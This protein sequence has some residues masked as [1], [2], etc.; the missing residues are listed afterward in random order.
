MPPTESATVAVVTGGAR[1]IGAAVVA[2][3]RDR[4]HPVVSLDTA[5]PDTARHGVRDIAC[6]IADPSQIS[7]AV[8]GARALG[9]ISVVVHCAAFQ[10]MLPWAELTTEEWNR[11]FRVNVDGAFHL[12]RE[13]VPDLR[14]HGGGRIVLITSSSYFQPPAGMTHY[15]ATK[16]ALTGMVRGLST[17]LGPDGITINA[18]APGLTATENAVAT[19]P[20]QHFA[21]VAARQA[22][23]RAG[24]PD[25]VASA[26]AYLASPDAGFITGQTVLVDGG[27]SRV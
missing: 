3:L 17:E 27:E 24:L 15:I 1:G 2:R 11:G 5:A 13:T 26:V 10:L 12:L 23:P 21:L 14:T 9:S 6:D 25:D 19:V 4:G 18:V 16:G 7:A 20:E 8:R 22:I